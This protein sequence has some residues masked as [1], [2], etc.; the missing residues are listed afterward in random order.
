M[1]PGQQVNRDN[2]PVR[3]LD[4]PGTHRATGAITSR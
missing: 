1:A 2:T 3:L 4:G